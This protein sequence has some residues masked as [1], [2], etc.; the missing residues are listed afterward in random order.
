[1]LQMS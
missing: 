1:M